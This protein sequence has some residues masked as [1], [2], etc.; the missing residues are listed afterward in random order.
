MSWHDLSQ[1]DSGLLHELPERLETGSLVA[2]VNVNL[3][4][5]S[6]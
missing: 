6:C 5:F 1:G 3:S 4:R 2:H